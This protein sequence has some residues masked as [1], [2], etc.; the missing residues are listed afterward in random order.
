MSSRTPATARA[1]DPTGRLQ[2]VQPLD[3]IPGLGAAPGGVGSRWCV[4]VAEAATAT[5][6]LL[7]PAGTVEWKTLAVRQLCGTWLEAGVADQL[8]H[9]AESAVRQ[10]AASIEDAGARGL[11]EVTA[12]LRVEISEELLVRAR[13]R[14]QASYREADA[15]RSRRRQARAG[16]LDPPDPLG[17]RRKV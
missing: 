2:E 8:E 5:A 10:G 12:T 1:H 3:R 6:G 14:V 11:R 17:T 4:P 7:S 13:E 9:E 16:W 15:S